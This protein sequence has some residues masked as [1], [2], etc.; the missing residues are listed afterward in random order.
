MD[1]VKANIYALNTQSQRIFLSAGFVKTDE[2]WH[3]YRLPR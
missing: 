1:T 3:E 2:E